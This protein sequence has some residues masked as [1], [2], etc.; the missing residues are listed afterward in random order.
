MT[1]WLAANCS[2]SSQDQA[3]CAPLQIGPLLAQVNK[4][5][6]RRQGLLVL[7][8]QSAV[9]PPLWVFQRCLRSFSLSSYPIAQSNYVNI[10]KSVLNKSVRK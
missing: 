1:I 7:N 2:L 4:R 3:L 6:R 8:E 5:P 9:H 10:L